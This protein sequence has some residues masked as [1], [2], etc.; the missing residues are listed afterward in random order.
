M[1]IKRV[2]GATVL[3]L[4]LAVVGC[5][6]TP[7][8]TDSGKGDAFDG[9]KPSALGYLEHRGRLYRL[10]DLLDPRFRAA[11][12]DPFVREFTARGLHAVWAGL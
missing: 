9:V 8:A 4:G 10:E 3:L 12:A 6:V 1:L 2:I 11:S 7:K 5:A